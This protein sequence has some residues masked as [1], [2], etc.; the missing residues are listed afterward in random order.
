LGV[1]CALC[2][3]CGADDGPSFA[4]E[5]PRIYLPSN[6]DRLTAAIASGQPEAMRFL[7]TV[8]RW[9]SGA[10]I[11]GIDGWQAALAGQL[12]GDPKYCAAA[13]RAVDANV[14]SELAL[15]RGSCWSVRVQT[16]S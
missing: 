13:V 1:V 2:A 16:I 15:I 7:S 5:H 14:V 8:D 6:R 11:Y 3:A 4:S 9:A 12:T 10:D